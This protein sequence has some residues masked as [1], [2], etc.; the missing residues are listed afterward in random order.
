LVSGYSGVGK[1]SLIHEVE[2]P[3]VRQNGYFAAGKFDQLERNI[4]YAAVVQALGALAR[5]LLAET[6][7][8]LEHW[9]QELTRALGESGQVMVELVP[10]LERIIGQQA[11]LPEL[12][13][14]ADAQHRFRRAFRE[15]IKVFARPSHPLVV[16]LDDLQWMDAS[17]PELIVDLFAHGDVRHLLLVGA[18]R[19]N[20]V[21]EGHL[22]LSCLRDLRER[23]PEA[24]RQVALAPLDETAVNQLVAETLRAGEQETRAL[25]RLIFDKTEGNPLFTSELL[26]SLQRDGAFT[27]RAAQG[28]WEWSLEKVQ[29]A[30]CSRS[31]PASA[32]N[33]TSTAWPGSRARARRR[34]PRRC[35]SPRCSGSCS[36]STRTIA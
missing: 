2:R 5:Q 31:P 18:Y 33:S 6:D 11:A 36:R 3:I 9:R 25:T 17:M 10:E 19:D 30:A 22:L 12:S 1:S 34:S 29:R 27:F 13:N 32:V 14:A 8:R 24:V 23:K 4:P 7:E 16:F 28:R 35:G 26:H 21:A 20:E 15:F